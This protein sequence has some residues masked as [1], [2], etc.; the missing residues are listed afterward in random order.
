MNSN[1]I[2]RA[3]AIATAL[4]FTLVGEA[5]AETARG[6]SKK[7]QIDGKAGLG[8]QRILVIPV[9]DSKYAYNASSRQLEAAFP[10]KHAEIV[11][12]YAQQAAFWKETSYG[13]VSFDTVVSSCF[14][15]IDQEFPNAGEAAFQPAHT[16]GAFTY[17]DTLSY[18]NIVVDYIVDPAAPVRT[19][20][21]TSDPAK[22]FST[23]QELID[24]MN[25]QLASAALEVDFDGTPEFFTG[26]LRFRVKTEESVTGSAVS[27]NYVASD[28][29]SRLNLG[30]VRPTVVTT[31][32]TGRVIVTSEGA[33]VPGSLRESTQ[34]TVNFNFAA[35]D[36]TTSSF[37]WNITRNDGTSIVGCVSGSTCPKWQSAGDL[38][39]VL[40]PQ[41]AATA[42]I[43][44]KLINGRS[45]LEFDIQL[46][47]TGVDFNS[48]TSSAPESVGVVLGIDGVK[49]QVG[50]GSGRKKTDQG[51]EVLVEEA[52]K[53]FL[54]VELVDDLGCLPSEVPNGSPSSST[55]KASLDTYFADFDAIH[56]ML[57]TDLGNVLRANA[58]VDPFVLDVPLTDGTAS[59]SYQLLSDISAL[60]LT[61]SAATVAHEVGHNLGFPD[62]YDVSTTFF[63]FKT[64][65]HENLTFVGQWDMMASH[66]AF[67]QTG[68]FNKQSYHGWISGDA[69]QN[70]T[71]ITI[72]PG[73]DETF[74]VTPLEYPSS[75]YDNNLAAPG[76]E[77]IAKMLILPFGDDTPAAGA[78]VPRHY[79]AVEN[80]QEN[81]DPT[82]AFNKML[83]GSGGIHVTDNMADLTLNGVDVKPI[84]RR[85]SHTLEEGPPYAKTEGDPVNIGD[86]LD[87]TL[88]FPSYPGISIQAIGSVPAPNPNLPPSTLVRVVYNTTETLDLKIEPWNAP[89][90]YATRSIWFERATS[91]VPPVNPARP[92]D[93]GNGTVPIYRDGYDPMANGGVPLNWIHIY[94][95]N[96]GTFAAEDV[97]IKVLMN[98]PGGIGDPEMWEEL[99]L[100]EA[101]PIP[102][103]G[104]TVFSVPWS[105]G[106]DVGTDRHT[107]I[108][109]EVWSWKVG[110]FGQVADINPFN[111]LAQENVHKMELVS[112]S[113][114][115]DVPFSV[116]VHN[117]FAQALNVKVEPQ[118]LL[119]G[120]EV[121]IA[122]PA[123]FMAGKSSRVF[124]GTLRWDSAVIPTPTTQN[125]Y[126]QFWQACNVSATSGI[127]APSYCGSTWSLTAY[128]DLGDAR[129]PLGGVSFESE[130][131][132]TA[133]VFS[134]A[135]SATN[136]D[137]V[138]TG[139]VEPAY[140][141]QLIRI[142]VKYP[143]GQHD[144][145]DVYTGFGGVFTVPFTPRERGPLVI[146]TEIPRGTWPYAPTTPQEIAI[147]A[148]APS[149]GSPTA[150]ATCHDGV[151]N[152]TETGV[153]CGGLSCGP[154][155]TATGNVTAQLLIQS[156]W[157]TGY[158]AVIKVSNATAQPA[159]GWRVTLNTLQSRIYTSWNA[160]FSGN[161]G[162]VLV[163]PQNWNSDIGAGGNVTT[164]GFCA[165]R[166]LG[167]TSTAVVT[168]ASGIF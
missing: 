85:H 114:W 140:K 76:G 52:L 141:G 33:S 31:P 167:S 48:V 117:S 164:A 63:D 126:D 11:E 86:T 3:W 121:E 36:G 39:L 16:T 111:N 74:V 18:S 96:K 165:D 147:D 153:D 81:P 160:Q 94:V 152:G 32:A 84:N 101:K 38:M 6:D 70:G 91:A 118:G 88:T 53:G 23:V 34:P 26:R 89:K 138:V 22:V 1:N 17:F 112:A 108:A 159:S 125:P 105:P 137:I 64:D 123:A 144:T 135:T 119:P 113:P 97:R 77:R 57:L 133:Q 134:S 161:V 37:S 40:R 122:E 68:A 104:A 55:L 28:L 98:S 93:V 20:T 19:A 136:G 115:H 29:Q 87:G 109:A 35:A 79:I 41:V 80:R 92:S 162:S 139:R 146:T 69:G 163:I 154:C 2:K 42:T 45:E 21:L 30:L 95:E 66:G 157:G 58:S 72:A 56:V 43:R 83:P 149:T 14:Y 4:V 107:C 65:F 145:V 90:V 127:N 110:S 46:S 67:P 158:C 7:I 103:G 25:G 8:D 12:K 15:R 124:S 82:G 24:H 156:D 13:V 99:E 59:Y 155:S 100:T 47:Q 131:K 130:G 143:S 10:M 50:Q 151:T 129:V 49:T 62:L 27:I 5:S 9:V 120:Y 60:G 44:D 61:D 106:V 128:A 132:P 148:C 75:A 142:V 71:V 102:A 150:V 73:T 166:T 78:L 51:A 168:A 116:E 54:N